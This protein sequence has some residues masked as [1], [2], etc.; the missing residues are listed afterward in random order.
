MQKNVPVGMHPQS[1]GPPK[2]SAGARQCA[3]LWKHFYTN[4]CL[5][6]FNVPSNVTFR[7]SNR[8][9]HINALEYPTNPMRFTFLP[10]LS[11]LVS[12]CLGLQMLSAMPT[13]LKQPPQATP[14][15]THPS[16]RSR[17]PN[18]T[19]RERLHPGLRLSN[20]SLR[21]RRLLTR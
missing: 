12:L 13:R 14:R 18:T 9:V 21:S 16:M 3:K 19:R 20:E 2:H 11:F 6:I 10:N 1:I 7:R 8:P 15:K 17:S 5:S 4:T